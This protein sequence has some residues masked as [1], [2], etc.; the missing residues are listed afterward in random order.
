MR[1]RMRGKTRLLFGALAMFL[2]AIIL[3][4]P[5]SAVTSPGNNLT[6]TPDNVSLNWT[7]ASINIISLVNNTF[8][9]IGNSSTSITP[10]Y[11]DANKYDAGG[12]YPGFDPTNYSI[13]FTNGLKFL[14]QNSSGAFINFTQML[15]QTNSTIYNLTALQFCP[16]GYYFGMF[17]ISQ[18]GTGDWANVS[19]AVNIPINPTN[20][21]YEPNN[22]AYAKGTLAAGGS[23]VHRY[24][25]NTSLA[26]N[27]TA[28]TINL[29]GYT[30]DVDLYLLNSSGALLAKSAENGS[31]REEI[32]VNLPA[33]SDMWQILIWGNVSSQQSY[34][35]NMYFST[36]NVTNTSSQNQKMTSINFGSLDALNNQ[37]SQIN[38]TLNNTDTT[39][40]PGVSERSEIYRV[41]NSNSRNTIGNY[42]FLVPP[43]ATKVKA[44]I[45]WTGGTRWTVSLND[46][47][48]N[49]LGNSS[50]KYMPGNLTGT[51]QEESV[52]YNGTINQNND[53]LWKLTIGNLSAI[54]GTDYYNITV[55]VWQNSAGWI[56]STFPS[57][58][59]TFNSSGSA[60]S[61]I[62]VS[63]QLS[64]QLPNITN[65]TYQGFIDYYYTSGW[66][67]RIPIYFNVLAGGLLVNN[68]LNTYSV[69]LNESIGFNRL[70]A[71]VLQ[72][73]LPFNNTGGQPAYFVNTTSNNTLYNGANNMSFAVGWPSNPI[74]AGSAGNITINVSI[75]T[76]LTGDSPGIY[77]GW[78]LLNTTNS[79]NS[80]SSS[81]P[82]NTFNISVS[83]NLSQYLIL[84]VTDIFPSFISNDTIINNITANI[85]VKLANGT[86]LSS[87]TTLL[88]QSNFYNLYLLEGNT[89]YGSTSVTPLQNLTNAGT[90]AW[91][92][93]CPG[94]SDYVNCKLNGSLPANILGGVY[95]LVASASV[96]TSVL[97]GTGAGLTGTG[98]GNVQTA[99]NQTAI[100]FTGT[101]D[102][103]NVAESSATT[104][105]VELRNYGPLAASNLQLR[106]D[107][108]SCTTVTATR[109][110]GNCTNKVAGSTA[111]DWNITTFSGYIPTCTLSWTLTASSVDTETN[112][113]DMS[114]EI[115]SNH[116]N[117]GNITGIMLTILNN[118]TAAA[119]QQQGQQ[120]TTTCSS[121]STCASTQ[122]CA[123]GSC[124]TLACPSGMTAVNHVC[125]RNEGKLE[126]TDYTQKVY[127][128]QGGSNS[129]RVTVKNS[130]GYN[131]TAKLVVT[132]VVDGLN[133]SVTPTSYSLGTGNSGIFTL[134]FSASGTINVGYYT[135]TAKTYADENSSVYAMKNITIGVQPAEQTKGE[136]NK[137]YGDLK[138]LFA[139][140]SSLFNQ[141]PASTEA[142]YTLANRTYQ[143]LLNMFT[144]IENQISAGNYLD[145]KTLLDEANASL[146]SFKQDVDQLRSGPILPILTDTMTLVAILVVILVVGGFLAYLLLPAKKGA[147]FHP[148]LGY[149]P[150]EKPPKVS[151]IKRLFSMKPKLSGQQKTLGEYKKEESQK[152]LQAAKPA[153][154]A[155]KP[156]EGKV[157][158]GSYQ[159]LDKFPLE[160]DQKKFK[161]K[162]D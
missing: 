160:Y 158:D 131:Y 161:E 77:S 89:S 10:K 53:G 99:V 108:G 73:T 16:P 105:T 114:V 91:A 57:S 93:V 162:K 71:N 29:S 25:F 87:I 75:N 41:E 15:N 124:V 49:F 82:F 58:G 147:G 128:L 152:L 67:T 46:S 86:I 149:T 65:G 94:G 110:S 6:V 64:L 156:A 72:I 47:S 151:L 40:W 56:N 130:G 103:G 21:F 148:A 68:T 36:I 4:F 101:T 70:G 7:G 150:H 83:V 78:V 85:T 97:G 33:A 66:N 115:N 81:F 20:T 50:V 24:Y 32:N 9:N 140:I 139:S 59:F 14:V 18:N 48:G 43:Y 74:N 132:S 62:N 100:S 61:S 5:G 127:V 125:T 104:Y 54:T 118:A 34:L 141:L 3:F 153:Q 13:C 155:Q 44:K 80:S 138:N 117:Y 11:F 2:A 121:N 12:E 88:N 143:R 42:Y 102:I 60:N 51:V 39:T 8:F 112:C 116:Q 145:A 69:N 157:Y 1:V 146:A 45:E 35:A 159:K 28:V 26:Q 30:E 111:A 52:L 136:I 133:S 126:I 79:T 154:P 90:G 38:I 37:S 22:T 19:A 31:A 109:N 122:Y 134:N 27:L 129:T 135:L 84:N 55:F 119:P 137:T 144:D 120:Q 107:R 123:G 98:S 63:L 23:V 113:D 96:N 106:F 76:S 95:Y 142:N 17:N 92:V